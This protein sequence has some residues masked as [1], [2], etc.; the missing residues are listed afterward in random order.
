MARQAELVAAPEPQAEQPR[1]ALEPAVPQST[2]ERFW[3]FFKKVNPHLLA[4]YHFRVYVRRVLEAVGGGLRLAF[5]A[6]PQHGKTEVTLA[7]IAFLVLEHEGRR[8][9]YVTYNQKRALSVARKFK[10]LLAHAGVV[11]SGGLAQIYLPG[12]GQ[13]LFTSV[14][15]G[16]T[17][18]PVDG[19][20]FID[21]PYKN[22]KEADSAAR[23]EL[24]EETYRDAVETRVHP[25]G[26]IF[27]LAT[28]WHPQ[29]L[30]GKLTG[31]EGWEYVNLQALAEGPVNDNGVVID[32]PN[33]RRVGEALF[34]E[35]WPVEELAKKRAKVLEF[36]WA[37]LY[38][39]RPR[40]K[41]GTVFHEPHFYTKRPTEFR[42]AFGLD[43]A[44]TAKTSADHSVCL[45]LWRAEHGPEGQPGPFFYVVNIDAKQVEAPA[46]ALTLKARHMQRP[47]FKM[48]WRASGTEK[49]GAQFLQRMKLPVVVSQP[50]GDKFVSATEVAIAWN[51]GRVLVP[52]EEAFPECK[53]WLYPFLDCVSNFT[54]TGNEF[55]DP[56]DALG[57][58]HAELDT[59]AVKSYSSMR[60]MRGSF[61]KRPE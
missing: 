49:M 53:E 58:A 17:G 4:P 24:V 6:P 27:V 55:D 47:L 1:P 7:L 31:E 22:R 59:R 33:G 54:G 20:V 51:D 8:W 23:R 52:D 46:F 43:L 10:R 5:A 14:D 34:P 19:A 30:T 40:P 29:D 25:G 41:G 21:D 12:G 2:E 15:G 13:I 3:A 26:S 28:R 56:V 50:P 36:T 57:N 44:S 61:P 37:A 48:R 11:A 38:Q 18:E 35:K 32:D 39:G 60:G 45:E 16:L 42:G 9:A